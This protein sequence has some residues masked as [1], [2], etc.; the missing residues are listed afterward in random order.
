MIIHSI[1]L[2]YT[3]SNQFAINRPNGSGD[4]LLL[5]LKTPAV[6]QLNGEKVVADKNSLIIF[7]KGTPQ[8]YS[9]NQGSYAND[10]IHFDADGESMPIVSAGYTEIR[11][12]PLDTVLQLPSSKQISKILKDLYL[13][14][15]SNNENRCESMDLLLRLLFVKLKELV[16][17]KSEDKIY[18]HYDAL[19]NLRSMIHRHPEE[20]WTIDRLAQQINLSPSHFQRLYRQTFGITCIADVISGKLQYAKTSLAATGDTIREIAAQCGYDNEEHFMRQFKQMTGMTPS[21]YRAR[22]K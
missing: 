22:F 11:N 4:Y 5:Y 8:I 17:Q 13:E 6:L 20:K 12:L 2:N 21:Q 18:S 15:I 9:A 1:G 19:L 10:F 14:Y 16:A 3:H 7:N